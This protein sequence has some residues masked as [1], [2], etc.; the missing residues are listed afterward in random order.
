VTAGAILDKTR[1][2][3][4]SWFAA[5]WHVTSQQNGVSAMRLK[6]LLGLGSYQT[7]WTMLH[8]LRRARTRPDRDRLSCAVEVD[9]T[10]VGGNAAGV[11]GRPGAIRV[12]GAHPR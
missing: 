4:T 12:D 8:K 3:L 2:P 1:T 11:H 6:Q 5:A 9:E 7:A 10:Y